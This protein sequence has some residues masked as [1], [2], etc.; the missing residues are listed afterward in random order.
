MEREEVRSSLDMVVG[1]KESLLLPV[2]KHGCQAHQSYSS[3]PE[4]CRELCLR[5]GPGTHN[6]EL[7]P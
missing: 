2:G 7:G 1:Y 3:R 5:T 6:V 4:P